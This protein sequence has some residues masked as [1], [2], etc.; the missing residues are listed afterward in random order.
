MKF[1]V[2]FQLLVLS[3]FFSNSL[4]AIEAHVV[5]VYMNGC[6]TKGAW[7]DPYQVNTCFESIDYICRFEADRDR[8]RTSCSTRGGSRSYVIYYDSVRC[9]AN[10]EYDPSTLRCKSQCEYGANPDGSCMDACQFKQSTGGERRLQWLAYVYGEQVTGACYGDFGATRCEL[11]RIPNDSTLCTDVSSGEFTQNT[12]CHGNFQ[13]TGNQCEGGT[14]FWGT[15]GPDDPIIP[16]DPTHD[17]DDPTGEIVDP[18]VLPDSSTNTIDPPD[19]D[20]EPDVEEP[21]TDDSTDTAVVSAITGL[22]K[23]VNSALHDLNS[24]INET[25]TTIANE[26]VA[27]KGSLVDNTQAIQ[28]QQI[29]DN[30]IYK[31]TKALIQQ[32]NAD[33]TTAV[34]KNSNAVNGL[35]EDLQGVSDSLGSLSDSLGDFFDG[36]GFSEPN[37]H[38]VPEVI[39][40]SSD[41]ISLNE[42]I[43]EKKKRFQILLKRL[44][45]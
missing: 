18:S 20:D 32:A 26:L 1:F 34:N 38:E 22:N 23:D 43:S 40:S 29:N 42:S 14:L 10:S 31:N 25:Q 17:P 9:P 27:V 45:G 3:L 6:A 41:F 44:R 37:A 8:F 30:A 4:F 16:T 2:R 39:F 21:D 12:L 36:S 15:N 35:G 19:V 13:F 33:I 5:D 7:V 24:D 28:E 11:S